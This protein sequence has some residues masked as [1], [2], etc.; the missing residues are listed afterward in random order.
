MSYLEEAAEQL[1]KA[2]RASYVATEMR[3][4]IAEGFTRLG[5]IEQGIVPP[6]WD[7]T[8]RSADDREAGE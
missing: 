1:R 7:P 6:G 5:A 4:K 8:A 3:L 2:G